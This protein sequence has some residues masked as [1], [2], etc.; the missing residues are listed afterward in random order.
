MR[1]N[2]CSNNDGNGFEVYSE[3]YGSSYSVDIEIGNCEFNSNNNNNNGV[4]LSLLPPVTVFC[5]NSSF[6]HNWDMGIHQKN[7][8]GTYIQNDVYWN[9]DYGVY[10]TESVG[11]N[12]FYYG[13]IYSN[14]TYEMYNDTGYAA[15]ARNCWW[16]D[17]TAAQMNAWGYSADIWL[18]YDVHDYY[19]SG[20]I[21]YRGWKTTPVDTS[22]DPVSYIIDPMDGT[23]MPP[24][25][26]TV[27][28]V[29][30]AYP[31]IFRVDMSTDGGS[32]WLPAVGKETWT[33][34]WTPLTGGT[35]NLVSRSEDND[36]NVEIPGSGVD[37]TIDEGLIH[38][39]GTLYEDETW[40]GIVSV[41]GDVEV[42]EGL[43]LTI[44]PGT[45]VIFAALRDDSIS[46]ADT[47]RCEIIVRGA[48]I[49]DGEPAD[50]ITFTSD[51]VF[52]DPK[53]YYG[54]RFIN[55]DDDIS[56]LDHCD[57]QYGHI[58]IA[59]SSTSPHI[60]NCRIGNHWHRGISGTPSAH[61][62]VIET[63]EIFQ[64]GS[65]SDGHGVY[66]KC[67]ADASLQFNGNHSHHN[68]AKGVYFDNYFIS[69][70]ILT[71]NDGTFNENGDDGV[72]VKHMYTSNGT[73]NFQGNES[74]N[75]DND[76]LEIYCDSYGSSYALNF[77][78]QD[79]RFD[80]NG[81]HGM[82]V[83]GKTS[84][85]LNCMNSQFIHNEEYGIYF[86]GGLA[87]FSYN[88]IADNEDYGVRFHNTQGITMFDQNSLYANDT[89]EMYNDSSYAV[90]AQSCW[91]GIEATAEMDAY[92]YPYNITKIYDIHDNSSKGQVDYRNWQSE[93]LPTITATAGPSFTPGPPTETPTTAPTGPPPTSTPITP[94]NT[95]EPTATITPTLVCLN[96]G[97]VDDNGR[98]TPRDSKL[99]FDIYLDI[100]TD[101]THDEWCSADCNDSGGVTPDDVQCIFQHYLQ[102]GCDCVDPIE[103]FN[104]FNRSFKTNRSPDL[105]NFLM[106]PSSLHNSAPR[107]SSRDA[108]LELQTSSDG[109]IKMAIHYDKTS[110]TLMLTLSIHP[111]RNAV[112]AW[113]FNLQ[114]QERI[115]GFKRAS[116]SDG[117][118]DWMFKGVER[119]DSA[120][121]A[122][123]FSSHLCIPADSETEALTFF[124]ELKP[125]R[126]ILEDDYILRLTDF[127]DDIKHF[128]AVFAS[129][130]KLNY[131]AI[132]DNHQLRD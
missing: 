102:M 79:C 34:D 38:S 96:D 19:G 7:G 39:W 101:P 25:D 55:A 128:N 115:L 75:N 116:F 77:S 106:E 76:G 12:R 51:E 24:G 44:L 41:T 80:L 83:V 89:Y 3:S 64:C 70:P 105:I 56:L 132:A 121:V 126:E 5:S 85:T 27:T 120:I 59:L 86:S 26:F 52:P 20:M 48:L 29:A 66:I 4:Y 95:P 73:L 46:G 92:G 62:L 18:L 78:F 58:G 112:Q 113:G 63:S 93:V 36:G 90:S 99:A 131:S 6:H 72:Y 47:S 49:A 125:N 68:Y 2:V 10:F 118:S 117:L 13:N 11:V 104:L 108:A 122:G 91:W 107:I 119:F 82:N 15:D 9:A 45:Y 42:P 67:S 23:V 61:E 43:T 129:S 14:D 54:I 74:Y 71:I 100:F 111:Y 130:E 60:S 33:W 8:K 81:N 114:Y 103:K 22:G 69:N 110:K 109:K 123:A 32:N 17:L 50:V 53:D 28:G 98:L 94:T 21:D 31:G 65:N 84:T 124:F 97:D 16:G 35:Y 40:S 1:G 127:V 30:C 57:I 87:T 37:V 88:E